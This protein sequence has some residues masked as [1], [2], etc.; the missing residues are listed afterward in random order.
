VPNVSL[1]AGLDV[2]LRG[3]GVVLDT[4]W[5]VIWGPKIVKREAYSSRRTTV[6][7]SKMI[8]I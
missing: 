7:G 5:D 2:N 3:F 6:L 8:K 4:G 1:E